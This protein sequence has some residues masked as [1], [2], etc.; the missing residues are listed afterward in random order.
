MISAVLVCIFGAIASLVTGVVVIFG[1]KRNEVFLTLIPILLTIS[2]TVSVLFY[3][4]D[5]LG[6]TNYGSQMALLLLITEQSVF[7]FGHWIFVGQ[8]LQ[9][10]F[11]LPIMLADAK[12]NLSI[13]E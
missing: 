4:M 7:T 12:V 8:Y 9:T 13:E 10:S 1:K 11:T 3:L 2:N 6:I 5:L